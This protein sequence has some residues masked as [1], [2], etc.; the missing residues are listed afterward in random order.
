MNRCWPTSPF[1]SSAPLLIETTMNGFVKVEDWIVDV[2]TEAGAE[3]MKL[4]SGRGV[5]PG[6]V[7]ESS[8]PGFMNQAPF[9]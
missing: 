4:R 5:S 9:G 3:Y 8:A 1:V 2:Y 6:L 7:S